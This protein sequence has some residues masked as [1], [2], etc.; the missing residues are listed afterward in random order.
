MDFFEKSYKREILK[1][2]EGQ[3]LYFPIEVP[4]NVEKIEVSYDYERFSFIKKANITEKEEIN[5]VD[6][7]VL[8]NNNTFRGASGSNKKYFEIN[9]RS[10]T[11]GYI[12]GPIEKGTWNIVL[13]AYKIEDDGCSVSINVKYTFKT[14]KLLK[15]DLHIH[16]TVSDGE[17]HVLDVIKIAKN[18]KLDYIF[19]SDH[20]NF[21]QN[22]FITPDDDITVIPAMELTNYKGHCNFLG[23]YK[24]PKKI[25]YNTKEEL[26]EIFEDAHKNGALISLNHPFDECGWKMGFDVDYDLLEIQNGIYNEVHY[27]STVGFW[28]KNLCEGKKIP[29][30]GGSD[31]HGIRLGRVLASP[32]TCLYSMSNGEGDILEAI[33]KGHSYVTNFRDD[34]EIFASVDKYILGD[35]V[36]KSIKENMKINIKN[37][38]LGDKIKVISNKG[39]K[40][41]DVPKKCFEMNIEIEQDDVDFYRIEVWRH[42]INGV[43]GL[44]LISNP[45]YFEKE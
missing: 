24:P 12:P 11:F 34:V 30:V 21:H 4:N 38:S 13:G 14:L 2:E 37:F 15:G 28:H 41:F 40:V 10:A 18:M 32:C 31:N 39:E 45:I 16:S 33:K 35:T 26:T 42:S 7:G 6:I 17:Y 5:I 36:P 25:F 22:M 8:G 27:K 1:S 43:F 19:L 23:M 44:T 9:Q 20:N 3:I 29:I